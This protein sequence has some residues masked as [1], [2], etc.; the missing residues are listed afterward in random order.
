M[1]FVRNLQAATVSATQ[2]PVGT[3]P[4]LVAAAAIPPPL[5]QQFVAVPNGAA[6]FGFASNFAASQG[7]P[8]ASGQQWVQG[9]FAG[10]VYAQT[11]AATIAIS[12][13]DYRG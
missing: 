12:C 4:V 1:T 3:N 13:F 9:S 11:A 5:R 8:I 6:Q 2:I 7:I 10:D